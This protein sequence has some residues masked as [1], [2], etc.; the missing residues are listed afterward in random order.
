[1][2]KITELKERTTNETLYPVTITEAILDK[3]G[4]DLETKLNGTTYT[5][6]TLENIQDIE[7]GDR[8]E[9][10]IHGIYGKVI[11]IEQLENSI[12]IV[13]ICDNSYTTHTEDL[14]E[15]NDYLLQFSYWTDLNEQTGVEWDITKVITERYIDNLVENGNISTIVNSLHTSVGTTNGQAGTILQNK[16]TEHNNYNNHIVLSKKDNN[17]LYCELNTDN[18][19]D[20]KVASNN[21]ETDTL[22]QLVTSNDLENKANTSDL[23]NVLA[24]SVVNSENFP[25]IDNITREDLKKDLFIDLW[26]RCYDCQYDVSKEKAFTCNGVALT[27]QE[28]I[29]VYNAPRIS[30]PRPTGL[31]GNFNSPDAKTLIFIPTVGLYTTQD[32]SFIARGSHINILRVGYTD[33]DVVWVSTLYQA[34]QSSNIE[35]IIGVIKLTD[36]VTANGVNGFT[37]ATNLKEIKIKN[38]KV[39]ITFQWQS[40]LSYESLRYLVDNASNTSPITVT[41]HSDVYAKLIGDT[42]SSAVTN[43]TTEELD[44]WQQILTDAAAKNITFTTV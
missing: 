20:I 18:T 36:T 25:D 23:S 22:G 40:E 37:S 8:I 5:E 19:I 34:F 27:Y 2:A 39:N 30:Y 14:Q 24:D 29:D 3:N 38:L 12:T 6:V 21:N 17:L 11:A 7:I 41:V 13:G 42:S 4:I 10:E 33:N 32:F 9:D 1:M 15:G 44:Q 43:I 16:N 28:A 31:S 35:K 26:T